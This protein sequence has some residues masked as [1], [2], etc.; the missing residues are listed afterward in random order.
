MWLT[1]PR[2]KVCL[3]GDCLRPDLGA[4]ASTPAIHDFPSCNFPQFNILPNPKVAPDLAE[5]RWP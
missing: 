4:L 5:A 2:K 1:T 3:Q